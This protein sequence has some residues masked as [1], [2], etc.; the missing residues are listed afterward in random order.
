MAMH[1]ECLG[2]V[3]DDGVIDREESPRVLIASDVRLYREG[4]ATVLAGFRRLTIVG[5]IPGS[6]LTLACLARLRPDVVL[7]DMALPGCLGLPAALRVEQP[8]KFVAFGVSEVGGVLACAEA[9]ISGYVGND[10]SAEDLVL[11]IEGAL[12]GEVLC[13]PQIVGALFQRLAALVHAP[14][15]DPSIPGLTRREL[16]IIELVDEG[17]SNKEIAR[18]LRIGPATVKNH[19]HNILEK[20]QV[21]RRAEAAAAIR[22]MNG[23]RLYARYSGAAQSRGSSPPVPAS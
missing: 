1:G 8:V 22:T 18:H 11:T 9:G 21:R 20:L 17:H 2:P 16:E 6:E 23:A 14:A 4:L 15:R 13:P 3:G 12:R 19:V 7:L 5:A 10:G